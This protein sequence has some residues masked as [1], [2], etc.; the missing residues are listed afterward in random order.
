LVYK[1]GLTGNIGCG[2]S[3]VGGMLQELGA[4]YVDADEVVHRLLAAGSPL[5]DDVISRFGSQVRAADGGVD[6]ARLGSIV[7]AD[8]AA[9]RDLERR[10][11]PAVRVELRRRMA[12]STAPAIVV[13]AIKLI[14]NRL[15]EE[16]DSV[17]L[18]TCRPEDQRRRLT[19]LR[20]M[21]PADA[22]RRI[23]AQPPQDEKLVFATVVID[24]SGTLEATRKQVAAA[25][26]SSCHP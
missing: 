18:V 4:E 22:D 23:A 25:W 5:A 2:K 6:R 15:H 24:N 16:M 20:G 14:E 7:F 12:E 10:L 17:W 19:E 9:L 13:D 11:H 8:A 21:S 26:K 3:V 1:I